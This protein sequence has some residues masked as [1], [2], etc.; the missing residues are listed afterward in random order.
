MKKDDWFILGFL[1][2]ML[3]L[4]ALA[5]LGK[6]NLITFKVSLLIYPMIVFFLLVFGESMIVML[7]KLL[8]SVTS[9]ITRFLLRK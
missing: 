7:M 9:S 3:G 4:A 2:V 6:Q 5:T 1:T 8:V